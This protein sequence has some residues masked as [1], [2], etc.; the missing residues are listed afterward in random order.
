MEITNKEFWAEFW[1]KVA[2]PQVVDRNLKNDRVISK[3]IEVYVPKA[4]GKRNAIEIGCA[5][6]KW[7]VFFNKEMGY[8]VDG[9]EYVEAAIEKTILNLKINGIKEDQFNI[10]VAD[11]LKWNKTK[12]YDVVF[13]L[14]FIEH[15]DDYKNV[16]DAHLKLLGKKGYLIIGVPRFKGI[17]YFLQRTIEAFSNVKLIDNH[18]LKVMDVERFKQYG[19]DRNL[20]PI[21]IGYV[22]GFEPALFPIN[23]VKNLFV[24]FFIKAMNK[25]FSILFGKV[26]SKF[27]SSYL[28]SIYK[29]N[30]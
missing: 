24:R 12:E 4:D 27:T 5:P 25:M 21:F 9:I 29:L 28:M 30:S 6:G 17:N 2:V 15:F 8:C 22:G 18:N 23:E 19:L 26:N 11:F 3:M 14:G 1:R 10:Y 16:M 7:L 13:S 20:E